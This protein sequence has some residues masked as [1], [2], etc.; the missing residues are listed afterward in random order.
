MTVSWSRAA[1][2]T[3][4]QSNHTGHGEGKAGYGLR[5]C[6]WHTNAA[7][8]K[9]GF[10]GGTGDKELACQCKRHKRCG[11]DSLGLDSLE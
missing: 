6:N 8:C 9:M 4:L 1:P 5:V 11:F 2:F 7:M 3:I 10:P